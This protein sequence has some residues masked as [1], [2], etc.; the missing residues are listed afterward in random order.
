MPLLNEFSIQ[1][2]SVREETA[3]DFPG[4]LEKLAK[5]GYTG[6]EFAGYG[7][8]PANE[9]RKYLDDFGLKS[10]GSHVMP[11]RL[12]ENLDEE[13]EYNMRLGTRH[14]IIPYVPIANRE[15][16]LRTAEFANSTGEKCVK[17]GFSF[18]YHNH[19]HEFTKDGDEYLLDILFAAVDPE[20]CKME[21][22]LYW[23][24]WA[25]VDPVAYMRKNTGRLN[26]LHLK[27]MKDRESR[28]CVDLGEGVLDFTEIITLGK[29]LGVEHYILEQERFDTDAFTGVRNGFNHI[30]SL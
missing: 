24:A 20:V 13:L 26:L 11:K 21:L 3:K 27:Q 10:I 1:L 18:G 8:I 23:T 29:E 17:A 4:T 7:G 30:M 14:I 19:N 2:Y 28:E 6:V 9:M 22:D 12:T 5:I 16:A 25:G 15:D